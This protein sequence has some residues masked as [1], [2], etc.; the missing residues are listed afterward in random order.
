MND[1]YK[2]GA[3]KLHDL[4]REKAGDCPDFRTAKMGAVPLPNVEVISEPSLSIL[5]DRLEDNNCDRARQIQAAH[6][7]PY[8]DSQH[9]INILLSK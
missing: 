5:P 6:R 2:H 1:Q 9:P 3:D 4:L 7:R 8:R